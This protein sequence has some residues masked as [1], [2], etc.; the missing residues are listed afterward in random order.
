MIIPFSLI[1]LKNKDLA[2]LFPQTYDDSALALQSHWQIM[3]F[4]AW[5][6]ADVVHIMMEIYTTSVIVANHL[7]T[8]NTPDSTD[9]DIRPKKTYCLSAFASDASYGNT[10]PVSALVQS[11][12]AIQISIPDSKSHISLYLGHIGLINCTRQQLYNRRKTAFWGRMQNIQASLVR[13]LYCL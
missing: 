4:D 5:K 10:V 11:S 8:I 1:C 6:E 3:T 9:P 12:G 2:E 7:Y 13:L